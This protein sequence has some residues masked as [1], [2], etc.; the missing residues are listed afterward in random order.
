VP[1]LFVLSSLALM[2]NTLKERPM[3]SLIG[4]GLLVLGLPAYAAWRRRAPNLSETSTG[5]EN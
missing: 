2:A 5:P 4:L 1:A 3:E